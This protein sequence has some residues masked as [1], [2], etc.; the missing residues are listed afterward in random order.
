MRNSTSSYTSTCDKCGKT[1]T[2]DCHYPPL[3]TIY[4]DDMRSGDFRSSDCHRPFMDLCEDCLK[5]L[6]QYLGGESRYHALVEEAA[7]YRS[8][9]NG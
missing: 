2:S 8:Y 5:G 3:R 6:L 4:L 1:Q 9:T 7:R